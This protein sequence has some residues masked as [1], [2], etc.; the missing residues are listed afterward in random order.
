MNSGYSDHNTVTCSLNI[1]YYEP[2][3][4]EKVIDYLTNVP[5]YEWRNGSDEQWSKYENILNEFSWYEISA[6]LGVCEKV[7]LL[8]SK[9][10]DTVSQCFENLV[11]RSK[12]RKEKVPKHI[13]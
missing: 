1:S 7:K 4:S 12:E 13:K 9:I 5:K 6:D 3:K 8:L 2:Q 10:E 11:E